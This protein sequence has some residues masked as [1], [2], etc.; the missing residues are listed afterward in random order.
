MYLFEEDN[1][2]QYISNSVREMKGKCVFNFN[3]TL[4]DTFII[5]SINF[6]IS[7]KELLIEKN[8]TNDTII[9]W[10]HDTS[11]CN[12]D[13]LC[14]SVS[15]FKKDSNETYFLNTDTINLRYRQVKK[16]KKNNVEIQDTTLNFKTSIV[17]G[18]K[19]GINKDIIIDFE[20]PL[21]SIDTSLIL[22]NEIIDS[23]KTSVKFKCVML[24]DFSFI[25]LF[26]LLIKEY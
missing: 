4:K 8:L 17:N 23:V 1:A 20:T 26:L 18:N 12:L 5:K 14:F 6:D 24:F 11:I 3:K 16:E 7:D 25:V 10:I 13:T 19:I 2:E 15:Y 22:L 9:Y 21:N